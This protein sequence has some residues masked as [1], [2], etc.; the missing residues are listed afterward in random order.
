MTAMERRNI[1]PEEQ[2]RAYI[3][4]IQV[5]KSKSEVAFL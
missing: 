4:S 2:R 5:E 3:A 1:V